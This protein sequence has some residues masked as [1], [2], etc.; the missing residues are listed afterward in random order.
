M[1]NGTKVVFEVDQYD[2]VLSI[3]QKIQ[4]REQIDMHDQIL[5]F[6]GKRL[7]NEY[8]LLDYNIKKESTLYLILNCRGD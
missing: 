7:Q 5:A 1:L 3:K 4:K 8:T 2:T 6:A